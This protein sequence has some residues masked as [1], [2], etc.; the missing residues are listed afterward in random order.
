MENPI[1][2]D[3]LS[4]NIAAN[5]LEVFSNDEG[6]RLGELG[7]YPGRE[8]TLLNIAPFGGPLAFSLGNSIIALRREEAKLIKVSPFYN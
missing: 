7:F 4:L 8:L 2:A 1:T 6:L 3:N 5:I